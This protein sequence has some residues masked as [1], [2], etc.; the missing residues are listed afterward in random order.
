MKLK[1]N[2]KTAI[3]D[4]LAKAENRSNDILQMLY[5]KLSGDHIIELYVDG[6]ADLHTKTSGI[7]G[8][9]Y[10]NGEE[11]DS[12]SEYFG[13]A[14]NNQAEYS[15]LIR[16]LEM[17]IE[18]NISSIKIFADSQLVV[19][20]IN[21]EYKVKHHNMIPL[22]TTALDL[23]NQFESWEIHHILRDKNKVAD[24]LSKAGMNKGR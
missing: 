17:A 13:D 9:F 19:R 14:T 1:Q 23:L 16:G 12:F 22:Y 7:G 6:A 11:I 2:E 21:G 18:M 3:K 15:A 8:V 24:Q 5:K 20:Q 4:L 10:Q